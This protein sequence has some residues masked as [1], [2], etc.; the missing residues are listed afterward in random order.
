MK[1]SLKLSL[2]ALALATGGTALAQKVM[3]DTRPTIEPKIK[4]REAVVAKKLGVPASSAGAASAPA[5][6]KK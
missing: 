1:A 3:A 5:P 6:K 2:A 4:A